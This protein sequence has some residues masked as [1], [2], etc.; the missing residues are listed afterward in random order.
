MSRK[1]KQIFAEIV[2][3]CR[4]PTPMSEIISKANV[5]HTYF[6]YAVEAGLIV[7]V[8]EAEPAWAGPPCHIYQAV[9]TLEDL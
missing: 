4:N 5:N 6:M 3:L 8:G 1:R 9:K 2:E 7:K